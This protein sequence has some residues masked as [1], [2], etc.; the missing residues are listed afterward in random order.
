M[1]E[2]SIYRQ[3][4]SALGSAWYAVGL[5]VL[6]FGLS[7][8]DRLILSLL[9]PDINRQFGTSDTQIGLLFGLGFGT[10]YALTGLPLAHLIDKHRRIPLVAAGV[11][12]WSLCTIASAF[13]PDFTWLFILRSGVA[14]GEAVL[15]PAVIS[16]IADMFPR[17]KR[18]LPTTVYTASGAAMYTGALVFGGAAFQ[19][20]TAM[21]GVLGLDPWQITLV[22]V[23]I[24]GL[25][26][27]PLLLFTVPEPSRM[28][29]SKVEQF[30][31]AGEAIGYFRK[32]GGLY[33]GLFLGVS[34]I[35]ICNT[36]KIAWTP[37]LLIRAHD[38]D[39][40][41]AGYIFGTVGLVCSLLGA[42]T[43]PTIVRIW[44]DRGRR[45]ALPTVFAAAVTASWVCFAI[46][47]VIPS[48]NLLIV[49]LGI[50]TFFSAAIAVL[51]PLLIQLITPARMRARAMALYLTATGFIGLG[52]GPAAAAFLS[53]RFFDGRFAIGSGMSTL[54]IIT[55]PI[56]SVAIW[57]IRN[58]YSIALAEAEAREADG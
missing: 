43:W 19:M 20:A 36:A 27:A 29:I 46:V 47:G 57:S 23:G 32:E 13:A 18:A 11:G 14:I 4:S 44:T 40:A 56:A 41:N 2:S 15:S 17:Q 1:S 6:L 37:T 12:L 53:D 42:M 5:F 10:V 7:F 31:T 33:G 49:A 45:N 51:A 55:G 58:R 48:T 35:S 3:Q 21:S 38:I 50:G 54:I 8:I 25:L 22:L 52:L 34:A 28:E 39:P 24:P 26:L 30:T 9:A 16:L